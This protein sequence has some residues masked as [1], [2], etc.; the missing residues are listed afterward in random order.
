VFDVIPHRDD[1]TA[2]L[3]RYRDIGHKAFDQRRFPNFF[4]GREGIPDLSGACSL[5]ALT[6]SAPQKGQSLIRAS[7]STTAK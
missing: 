5:A 4:F 1:L 2:F 3:I 6:I 7:F